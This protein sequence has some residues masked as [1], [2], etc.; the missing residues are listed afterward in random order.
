MIFNEHRPEIFLKRHFKNIKMDPDNIITKYHQKRKPY[1]DSKLDQSF[2]KFCLSQD[3]LRHIKTNF[4]TEKF[5][6]ILWSLIV[7]L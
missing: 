1:R 4:I 6:S 7:R 3:Y 2:T 5:M